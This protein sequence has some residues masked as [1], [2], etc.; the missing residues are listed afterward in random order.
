[1]SKVVRIAIGVAA[2]VAAP[3]TGGTS[4]AF[5]GGFLAS[6]GA[7][8]V[9]GAAL[10][11]IAGRP[12][13]AGMGGIKGNVRGTTEAHS[14]V[15]GRARVGGVLTHLGTT[16]TDNQFLWIALAH[17]ITHRGGADKIGRVWLDETEI[18]EVQ[19]TVTSVND[20]LG[21]PMQRITVTGGKF[22]GLVQI[23]FR[24]GTAI[25][26]A[27]PDLA[28]VG[29]QAT[30]YAR[31]CA[32]STVRL[33][34][35]VN[36]DKAFNEA[37]Q[38]RIPVITV[39]LYGNRVYDPRL[40]STAGG[41]GAQRAADPT[42]WTWSDNAALCAA[43]YSIMPYSDGGEGV[44]PADTDWFSVA[45][46]A[47]VCDQVPTGGGKLYR[48][49]GLLTTTALR[50]ENVSQL[51]DAMQGARAEVGT[52]Y[53]YFAGTWRTPTFAI[54]DTWLREAPT[55]SP[56]KSLDDI[57]NQ[58]R[59]T[60]LDSAQSY[61]K[62][63]V[64]PYVN[65]AFVTQ[66]GGRTLIREVHFPTCPDVNQAQRMGALLGRKSRR[67]MSIQLALNWKGNTIETWETGTITLP[68]RD[69]QGRTFRIVS[70]RPTE[71]GPEVVLQAD[72]AADYGDITPQ[73]VPVAPVQTPTLTTPPTLTGLTAIGS[74]D[75]ID[76]SWT[77]TDTYKASTVV[78]VRKP[79]GTG[80]AGTYTFRAS[81][82]GTTWRD[83]ELSGNTFSYKVYTVLRTGQRGLDSA[84]V[85]AAAIK[86]PDNLAELDPAVQATID[87]ALNADGT[88]KAARVNTAAFATGIQPVSIVSALPNPA[89][90]TGP[91]TVF[92]TTDSK[93]YRYTGTAWTALV[94]TTDLSGTI[95]ANQIADAAISTAKFAAGIQ[96]VGIVGALPNPAGYAGPSTVLLTTDGKLYRYFS[97]A[98]TAAVP[99]V[100][101]AGAIT[102]TQITDNAITTAKIAAGAITATQIA[103]GT[104]TAS[105]IA[106]NTITAGQ[107]AAGAVTASEIAASAIT[108]TKIF[109]GDLSNIIRNGD[110]AYDTVGGVA[111]GY[112]TGVLVRDS[113]G[114]LF[115]N[116][117]KPRYMTITVRDN[118]G[119]TFPVVPG[120]QFN[121]SY[122]AKTGAGQ[123]NSATIGLRWNNAAGAAISFS[124]PTSAT[125]ATAADW[126]RFSTN[127]TAP[128]GAAS[129]SLYPL[130][131][132][133]AGVQVQEWGFTAIV[134]RRAV[135]AELVVDGTITAAKIAANTV[136]AAQIAAGTITA[137]QIAA[138]TITAGQIAAAAISATEIAA[139][140][141]FASKLTV[142]D[143][144]NLILN[145]EFKDGLDGWTILGAASP[146]AEAIAP[147]TD[148]RRYR[149]RIPGSAG[150]AANSL[151]WARNIDVMPG[152]A[153]YI[154]CDAYNTGAAANVGFY[155]EFRDNAGAL[156]GSGTIA[157]SSAGTWVA[158]SGRFTVPALGKQLLLFTSASVPA[159]TTYFTNFRVR[160]ALTG[161]LVVDGTITADKLN[162][163]TLSAITA[164]V[165]T[166]DVSAAGYVRSGQTAFNAGTGFW[167]GNDAG[168]P[169]LSIGTAGGNRLT[170][171]GTN[172][173][174]STTSSNIQTTGV[175]TGS[176]TARDV[177]TG[178][179]RA[180]SGAV[181]L[182]T[183]GTVTT[184]ENGTVTTVGN[185]YTPTTTNIGASY[186]VR[187]L[188]TSKTGTG[189]ETATYSTW[190]QLNANRSVSMT[191]S[192]NQETIL[193]VSMSLSTSSTGS[194]SQSI[195]GLTVSLARGPV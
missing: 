13:T 11:I 8:L 126:T 179:T 87:A 56:R 92:L 61:A 112:S 139:G 16:G 155:Y 19:M 32:T 1:M 42:T 20:T 107:I 142:S 5:L 119:P 117:P 64:A 120:E 85:S 95:V 180:V 57:Y 161:E 100:D 97:G 91:R 78:I 151:R 167:I 72:D 144:S 131:N 162:V 51:L 3:F 76:L 123:V 82:V 156:A 185:W 60:T 168:T 23:T 55:I 26:G 96:P 14:I 184:T 116:C 136:T 194:P 113:G 141:V 80:V 138:N 89:G 86:P 148:V 22:A 130:I 37:F 133:T 160:R 73:A 173:V 46:A 83:V 38:G 93:L 189:T 190:Q 79:G 172:L 52:Y 99:A 143:P 158:P 62:I 27:D 4:L 140:A 193:N 122:Y 40:D 28:A 75:G 68:G 18:S 115:T 175:T 114:A 191:T 152:E 50:R 178:G 169:K 132:S 84:A 186:W 118:A 6:A 145:A 181:T 81:T 106:A 58:V 59:I 15:L 176:Y 182:N 137:T 177:D 124:F 110:F 183:N 43:T 108:A 171:D 101:L 170:W 45:A 77:V 135:N 7:A 44:L 29:G 17:S 121:V 65:A 163:A 9:L 49:S 125:L 35:N 192:V 153:F 30:D 127:L 41:S 39:E 166:L 48:C 102:T 36:D 188:K 174:L 12:A 147:G 187:F 10:E 54:D 33:F 71:L 67:Q 74:T 2:V 53:T 128:A 25:Q 134:V 88:I 21:L 47:N 63:E 195:G 34:R 105:Q 66:D 111:D 98:W 129:A 24:R 69:F 164:N 94:P 157:L 149:V 154:S 159:N 90:Y 103:A 146:V 150:N 70:F 109:V 31:G 104:I 165:G